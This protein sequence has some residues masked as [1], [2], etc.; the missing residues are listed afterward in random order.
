VR[1]TAYALG[2]ILR[3]AEDGYKGAW[4]HAGIDIDGPMGK[5]APNDATRSDAFAARNGY[6]L[7]QKDVHSRGA[8]ETA[9]LRLAASGGPAH[10]NMEAIDASG[11]L[12]LEPNLSD[13]AARGGAWW[14]KDGW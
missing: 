7:L 3:L 8:R 6:I 13:D 12:E 14:F 9:E 2:S 11:V 5:Y 1:D 4:D 10:L